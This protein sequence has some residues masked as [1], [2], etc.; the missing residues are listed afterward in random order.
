MASKP[1]VVAKSPI[2]GTIYAGTLLKDQQTW[3]SNRSDVTGMACAAV[4]EHV[5]EKGGAIEVTCNGKPL[6]E[7][8]VKDLRND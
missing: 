3:S 6:F 8:T 7:I 1:I 2:T 4:A 5:I